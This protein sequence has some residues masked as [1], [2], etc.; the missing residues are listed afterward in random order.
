M[1]EREL[2]LA[3]GSEFKVTRVFMENGQVQVYGEV[4]PPNKGVV[5][6]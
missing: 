1:S 3:R 5:H 4:L 6:E 2:L